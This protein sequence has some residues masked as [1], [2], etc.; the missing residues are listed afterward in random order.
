MA[1]AESCGAA[2][3]QLSGNK[4]AGTGGFAEV[5]LGEHIYLKSYAALKVLHTVLTHEEQQAFIKEAQTLVHLQHPNIVHLL[6]F[7]VQEG[8]PF[9]IMDYAPG[10]NLRQRHPR[11]ERLP[12]ATIVPYVQ[13][14]ATALS[15]AHMLQVI[16]RDIKPENMLLGS[17]QS[18]LLSDFGLAMLTQAPFEA[19]MRSR[20]GTLGYMAPC[21]SLHRQTEQEQEALCPHP[22]TCLI[23]L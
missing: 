15:Y 13:Q 5:Y 16:H 1:H 6:D 8:I 14:I 12:L 4:T 22:S 20:A 10:G 17:Q 23:N 2:V 18:I 7:S 11:G 3:G 21:L 19:Y 9:L